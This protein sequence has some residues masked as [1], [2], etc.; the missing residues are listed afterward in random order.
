MGYPALLFRRRDWVRK[1][2][3]N[4]SLQIASDYD[5]VCW[6]AG[7][8]AFVGTQECVYLKREHEANLSCQSSRSWQEV[9]CVKARYLADAPWLLRDPV[10]SK[11]IREEFMWVGYWLREANQYSAAWQCFTSAGR[12]WGWRSG[13]GLACPQNNPHWLRWK[14]TGQAAPRLLSFY[15]K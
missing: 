2:G 1:G 8:G 10:F 9:L 5:L 14:C 15:N 13:P 3:L 6:L 4:E 7:R 12:L 11:R